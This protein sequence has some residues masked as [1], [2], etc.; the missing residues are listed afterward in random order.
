MG[1]LTCLESALVEGMM[2]IGR[3]LSD[4]SFDY[5]QAELKDPNDPVTEK[6]RSTEKSLR[7]LMQ[8]IVVADFTVVGEEYGSDPFNPD[9]RYRGHIDPIDGTKS[10]CFQDFDSAIGL[11]VEDI[12]YPGVG[13]IGIVYDFMRDIMYVASH[14]N[15]FAKLHRG[16]PV[17]NVDRP[18]LPQRPR[19]LVEGTEKEVEALYRHLKQEGCSP[20][21]NS[22]SMLLS[23]A[24]TAF[25]TYDGFVSFP[26]EKSRGK[27]WDV[28][29]GS[30]MLHQRE[31]LGRDGFTF[32]RFTD[33]RTYDLNHPE[34]GFIALPEGLRKQVRDYLCLN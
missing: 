19:I 32:R 24:Q 1:A 18:N 22:G 23:M 28:A 30:V 27:S 4:E 21:I 14:C 9:A 26:R 31:R 7:K 15:G 12:Q 13:V 29:A 5:S 11:G 6:D 16:K 17:R 34:T 25:M 2:V 3:R 33:D 10:F 20:Y 8:D